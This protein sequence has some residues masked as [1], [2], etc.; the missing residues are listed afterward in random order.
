M[1]AFRLPLVTVS[2]TL[3]STA[4][5]VKGRRKIARHAKPKLFKLIPFL[6][7]AYRCA[8]PQ[9]LDASASLHTKVIEQ[10]SEIVVTGGIASLN[11][12]EAFQK[13]LGGECAK[14]HERLDQRDESMII[15]SGYGSEHIPGLIEATSL[16]KYLC[17]V[18]LR[19]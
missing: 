16:F 10:S 13:K 2:D 12:N 5:L 4:S 19:F 3:E 1:H 18:Y 17:G 9:V 14:H 11:A 8:I 15:F 6:A 7:S